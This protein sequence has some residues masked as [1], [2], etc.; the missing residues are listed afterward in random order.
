MSATWREEP[1][2]VLAPPGLVGI[3]RAILRGGPLV[4]LLLLGLALKLLLRIVEKPLCH[5]RRPVTPW[6]TVLVCRAALRV[7]GLRSKVH[8][9]P[10]ARGGS[11][12]ANHA[13]WLD[14]LALNAQAPV[15]FV[16][17]ADVAGW[18][19]I[20]LLAQ[21]TGTLFIRRDSRA[22][23]IEQARAVT[24]RLLAGETLLLFPEGTSTDGRRVLPFKPTLFAGFLAP[25]LPRDLS[26]QPVTLSWQA[27][28]G[29]DPRFH[30]W[31]GD[32]EFGP[33]ALMVLAERSPGAVRITFHPPIPVAGRD[34]KALA[35][36]CEA[37][38]RSAL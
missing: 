23:S 12:V 11:M 13:S 3:I 38:V 15:V 27:P 1:E 16:A 26:V 18:P 33:H 35:A 5:P 25:D 32:M 2:P 30:A 8:G 31:W 28:E 4:L 19:G 10:L 34:R 36:E 37:A 6:I 22:Q 14:I 21:A 7:L 9:R 24:Q 20:G 17:K 29:K